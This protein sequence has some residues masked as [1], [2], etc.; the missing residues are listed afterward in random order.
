MIRTR[1]FFALLVPSCLTIFTTPVFAE[2]GELPEKDER[3][4]PPK[5][6]ETPWAFPE[7]KTR[8]EW[9][10]RA[11]EI[12]ENVLVSC[13]LWPMPKKT[14]LKAEIF[15]RIERDGYSVEKV[16]FQSYPGFYV[17][18]NLYRPLGKGKGP[19]PAVLNPHG[20]W[21]NGRLAD[22]KEGSIAARCISFARQGMVAFSWDM[23]GYNDTMQLGPHRQIAT[24]RVN[25]LWNISLMGLQTWNSIRSVDFLEGLQDVDKTRIG[26]TGESG[27]GTQTF[28]LGAVE[29][30][31]AAQAPAVMVSH[32]YQGGCL[33]ENAPGL[34][35][36]Y[37]NMEI[38]ARPAPRPQ[39]LVAATGDWTR[40][41][42]TVEGPAIEKIYAL[43]DAS[44]RFRY[45]RYD[46]NHNY[47]QRSREAVYDFFG[48]WLLHASSS[49]SLKEA[50]YT[51]EPDDDLLVWHDRKL[52]ADALNEQQLIAAIIKSDREQ[53]TALRPKDNAS[54]ENYRRNIMPLWKHTL[55]VELP[56]SNL[57]VDR[58]SDKKGEGY[59][60]AKLAVG[61]SGQHDRLPALFLTPEKDAYAVLVL[62]AHPNGKATYLNEQGHPKGLAKLLLEQHHPVMLVDVFLTGDLANEKA[63]A[64]R[65]HLSSYFSAYNRTDLEERVQDLITTCGVGQT[66][67]KGRRVII[68]GQGRAGLW[69][70]L[71]APAAAGVVADCDELD[72]DNDA[73][74]LDKELFSPGLRRMGSF[75]GAAALAAP[76]PL[77]TY[78]TGAKFSTELLRASYR[79]AGAPK[80][81][82]SKPGKLSDEAIAEWIGGLK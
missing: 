82:E 2:K 36:Q 5:V 50:P 61:R 29:E 19:F 72:D 1:N 13:G 17:A 24:N 40:A 27:G 20:H 73:A 8:G 35:V 58:L 78:N 25:L 69:A 77:L 22:T 21:P 56:E 39:I 28:I 16:Y 14:P 33:C 70:L 59:R 31:L 42:L 45:V 57:V 68:C 76:K 26:C 49:E 81:F 30:R 44:D 51:K 9:E 10:A 32:S 62:L 48:R 6:I 63:S 46:A 66:H 55:Q 11:R 64:A 53:L 18:G 23:I 75:Q 67:S 65:K 80:K 3:A 43:F 79:A 12:R 41:T 74:L 15:G 38:A 54:L 47:N 34:R 71:A 7:I 60:I 37:S 4:G 52:P